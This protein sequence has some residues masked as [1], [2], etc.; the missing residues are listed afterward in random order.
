MSESRGNERKHSPAPSPGPS[1]SAGGPLWRK[2]PFLLFHY[3]SLFIAVAAAA[4]VLGLVVA[5]SPLYLSSAASGALEEQF[6]TVTPSTAGLTVVQYGSIP[7]MGVLESLERRSET[8][9]EGTRSIPADQEPIRSLIGPDAVITA[10][11]YRGEPVQVRLAART[12]ASDNI[13]II[14]EASGD[15]LY[16][17]D[18]QAASLGV[19]AGD[20]VTILG[21][22]KSEVSVRVAG[23]YEELASQPGTEY[24]QPIGDL[25]YGDGDSTPPGFML[26]S[27][28]QIAGLSEELQDRR[29]LSRW[30]YPVR[31]TLSLEEG[32]AAAG[33]IR[34]I[35]ED[36]EARSAQGGE[37]QFA[38]HFTALP[39]LLRGARET[40]GGVESPIG[41]M[42]LAGRLVALVVIAAAGVYGIRR[43]R[44]ETTV[45]SAR[46][47]G[48]S[49]LGLKAALESIVPIAFGVAV[50]WAASLLLVRLM[51]PG[52]RLDPGAPTD[53]LWSALYAG[54]AAVI[55]VGVASS[56][57]SRREAAGAFARLPA[58]TN[59]PWEFALLVLAGLSFYQ[60]DAQGIAT[61]DA[62]VPP[63]IDLFVLAFPILFIAGAAGLATRILGL[64]LPKLRDLW[65]TSSAPAYLASRRLAS[66]PRLALMLVTASAL[67]IGVLS[68]AGTLVESV[69]ATSDAKARVSV[70]SDYAA[71]VIL[72]SELPDDLPFPATIVEELDLV[73]F[74]GTG[75][76]VTILAVEPDSLAHAAFWSDDFSSSSLSRL[77]TEIAQPGDDALP[78]LVVG[79]DNDYA[80]EGLELYDTHVP[81]DVIDEP[82]AFPGMSTLEPTVIVDAGALEASFE[83]FHG[84][85]TSA[86]RTDL[87]WAKGDADEISRALGRT[88]LS[89]G[90]ER[91]AE[92]S[93]ATPS[94]LAVS[95]TFGFLQALGAIVGMVVLAGM[96]LY[97]QSRQRAGIV[98]FALAR[99]MGLKP[100]SYRLSVLLELFVLLGSALVIG[101]VLSLVAARIIYTRFDLFPALPPAPLW[102]V[103][104]VVFGA[105]VVVLAI[106]AWVGAWRVQKTAQRAKVS[107]VLRL[108]E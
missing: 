89:F 90:L 77:M 67:A 36:L 96:L 32:A 14:S 63:E 35:E 80:E 21:S 68:Y 53:A 73:E 4:L 40:V 75:Q 18:R 91:S 39:D 43:R 62:A 28:S 56:F 107:E 27:F 84:E 59:I 101:I 60:L 94:F 49:A 10:A 9:A 19:A 61:G 71:Q 30:E 23:I 8:L 34:G 15:G 6:R 81:V 20:S 2:A 5:S 72:G 26:G 92:L 38:E 24:W 74:S 33:V 98:S 97:L 69:D 83:K 87:I 57:A 42:S 25:V 108:A 55:V 11:E 76:G 102:R 58:V 16:I 7:G 46:G 47:I 17:T 86:P 29:P 31:T 66:A 22:G 93:K 65:K 12:D 64:L 104:L 1:L 103:P 78:I 51:G 106:A 52:E 48:P 13:T 70:G 50:G 54:I 41:I 44:I 37:F 82:M 3:P 105:T 79:D 85:I 100:S 88:S 99:R 45:L 95:W